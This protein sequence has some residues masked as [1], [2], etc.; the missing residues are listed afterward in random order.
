MLQLGWKRLFY[1]HRLL[2]CIDTLHESEMLFGIKG[3]SFDNLKINVFV[4][5]PTFF[6]IDE[7][8]TCLN[9]ALWF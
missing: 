3:K 7:L 1:R 2:F 9:T 4:I 8:I 5:S 6:L